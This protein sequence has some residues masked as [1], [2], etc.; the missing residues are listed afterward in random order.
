M[1][2]LIESLALAGPSVTCHLPALGSQDLRLRVQQDSGVEG[3]SRSSFCGCAH[4]WVEV[5]AVA[6]L[7][8]GRRLTSAH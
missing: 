6:Q 3:S 2:A 5:P 4:S 8:L 7:N 1:A